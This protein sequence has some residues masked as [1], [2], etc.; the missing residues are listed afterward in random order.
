MIINRKPLSTAE[1]AEYIKKSEDSGTDMKDFIKKFIKL[2][3]KEAK[4]LKQKLLA[5]DLMKLREEII[6]KIIDI[7][8]ENTEDLNKIFV[9]VN[10]NE[11][12]TK[13]ILETVKEFK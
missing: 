2:N 8:P 10:L 4:E 7:M 5:L 13:Q 9:G 11:D 1:V 6:V 3:P 12:E